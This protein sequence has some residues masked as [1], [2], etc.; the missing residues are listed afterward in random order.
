MMS[1]FCENL[2][3]NALYVVYVYMNRKVKICLF[4]SKKTK[5]KWHEFLQHIIPG[6]K[7]NNLASLCSDASHFGEAAAALLMRASCIQLWWYHAKMATWW[8]SNRIWRGSC[9]LNGILEQRE[10]GLFF[11]LSSLM[12]CFCLTCAT[13]DRWGTNTRV[14]L[15]R[16][17]E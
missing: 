7:R 2:L 13:K 8:T 5:L 15:I 1:P 9:G 6:S 3:Y 10:E 17:P 16:L 11:F 14:V 4:K 12:S